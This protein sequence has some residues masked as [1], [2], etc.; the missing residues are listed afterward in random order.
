MPIP[1]PTQALGL[2]EALRTALIIKAGGQP[3]DKR[4]LY[5]LATALHGLDTRN[6]QHR[7]LQQ[8]CQVVDDLVLCFKDKT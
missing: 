5:E 3:D 4:S 7:L 2:A 6:E 8:A 1:S